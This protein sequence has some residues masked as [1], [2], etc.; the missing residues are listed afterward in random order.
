MIQYSAAQVIDLK[1]RVVLM[2]AFAGMAITHSIFAYATSESWAKLAST[3]WL[4][5]LALAA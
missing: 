5:P 1:Q 2:P 4:R 3:D